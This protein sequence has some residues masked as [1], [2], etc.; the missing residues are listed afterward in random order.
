MQQHAKGHTVFYDFIGLF[1]VYYTETAGM[2]I[3][4][5]LA[6]LGIVVVGISLWRIAASSH[7]SIANVLRVFGLIF[8]LHFIGFILAFGLPILMAVLFDSGDRSMTWFTNKWLVIG[9]YIAPSLFGLCMP[10]LLYLSFNRNVSGERFIFTE[11]NK[12]QFLV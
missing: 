6:V 11:I 4:I 2:I 9:L 10:T 7:M 5:C 3:N 1:F 12:K 8:L